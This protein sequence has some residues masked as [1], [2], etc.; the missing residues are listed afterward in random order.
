MLRN[1]DGRCLHSW[2]FRALLG[3][4]QKKSRNARHVNARKIVAIVQGGENFPCS[5]P[6]VKC[7]PS[8]WCEK[9]SCL[10]FSEFLWTTVFQTLGS[11]FLISQF[12][13]IWISEAGS[14]GVK[15]REREINALFSSPPSAASASWPVR[16]RL[17]RKKARAEVKLS[18]FDP[19]WPNY[20]LSHRSRASWM[21]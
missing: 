21:Q 12:P 1:Y 16:R 2:D 17:D 14:E 19:Q 10:C 18:Y 15:E 20:F 4:R 13:D 6:C 7:S 9:R 8:L 11:C 5:K 3:S